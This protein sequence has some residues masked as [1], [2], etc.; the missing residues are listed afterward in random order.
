VAGEKH[1]LKTIIDFVNAIFY[2][3]TGHCLSF[4]VV[5]FGIATPDTAIAGEIQVYSCR[6]PHAADR[7][8][9]GSGQIQRKVAWIKANPTINDIYMISW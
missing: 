2:C 4:A 6:L 5:I 7:G 9:D 8:G 1:Q 3:D